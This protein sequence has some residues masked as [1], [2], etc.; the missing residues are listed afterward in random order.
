MF[1][2]L[3]PIALFLAAGSA[4]AQTA[5][6]RE[7]GFADLD[8]GSVEG[9][10][11]L[12]NRLRRAVISVCGTADNADLRQVRTVRKCRAAAAELARRDAERVIARYQA[13]SERLAARR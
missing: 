10:A 4:W 6:T 8:L 12:D 3:T 5:P 11:S 7:V 1:K 13:Q 2:Y 9:R